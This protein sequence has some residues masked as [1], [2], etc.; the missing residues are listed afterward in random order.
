MKKSLVKF[1]ALAFAVAI[2]STSFAAD[3]AK[4]DKKGLTGK[5]STV[6]DGSIT[7]AN[8]KL[9]DQSFKTGSDT[10]VLKADGSAGSLSDLKSGSHV[11]I[12]PDPTGEQASQIQIVEHKKKDGAETSG[13]KNKKA[14]DTD[15]AKSSTNE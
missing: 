3:G 7:V 10:K 14:K 9:G 12:T 11:R 4:E 15:A 1:T 13:K 5:I 8:K 6:A 2:A